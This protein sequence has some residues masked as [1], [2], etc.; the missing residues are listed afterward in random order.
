MFLYFM[1]NVKI[2]IGDCLFGVESVIETFTGL[3]HIPVMVNTC[4]RCARICNSLIA[5]F[6][7]AANEVKK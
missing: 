4:S 2:I 5:A 6:K 1:W 7:D 3:L